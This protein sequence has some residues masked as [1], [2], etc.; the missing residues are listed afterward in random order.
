MNEREAVRVI[1]LDELGRTLLFRGGE[2]GDVYWFTPGGGLDPGEDLERAARREVF[3]EAGLV[4]GELGPALR[5]ER[6]EF[7]FEGELIRQ[8]Q[9]FFRV[10][11]EQPEISTSGW[12]EV[13]RRAVTAHRWWTREQVKCSQ[14]RIYPEDLLDWMD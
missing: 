6:I 4:F 14:E 11:V 2:P 8:R 13:E 10:R 5:S 9:T 12:T 7:V 1:L 3:E